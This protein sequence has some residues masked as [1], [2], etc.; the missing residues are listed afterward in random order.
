[1]IAVDLA[2]AEDVGDAYRFN[3]VADYLLF[4]PCTG[5][6]ERESAGLVLFENLRSFNDVFE[7]VGV[8][9]GADVGD[10]EFAA[11][12]VEDVLVDRCVWCLEVVE[13]YRGSNDVSVF[14]IQ[15][16]VFE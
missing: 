9:H 13:I 16:V 3:E 7:S 4:S 2:G 15:W 11:G 1:M 6:H 8:A 12:V 14:G 5:D 10:D